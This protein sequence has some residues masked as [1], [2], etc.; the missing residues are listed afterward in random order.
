[1]LAFQSTTYSRSYDDS[2]ND[3]LHCSF[4]RGQ[5][6]RCGLD[7]AKAD[8]ILN[9]QIAEFENLIKAVE[10]GDKAVAVASAQKIGKLE[11]EIKTVKITKSKKAELEAKIATQTSQL[12]SRLQTATM[13]AVSSGKLTQADAMEIANAIK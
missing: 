6:D 5:Y 2:G 13:K 4:V 1:L 8:K 7:N 10:N 11:R 12:S 9:E 3:R